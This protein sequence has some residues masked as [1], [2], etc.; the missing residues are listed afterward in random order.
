[1][2]KRESGADRETK[3]LHESQLAAL[4]LT[5]ISDNLSEGGQLVVIEWIGKS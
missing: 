1:M 2:A 5:V 3:L 4:V